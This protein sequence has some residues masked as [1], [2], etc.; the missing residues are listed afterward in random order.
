VD[1]GADQDVN[2]S[3]GATID[4]TVTDDGE[5]DPPGT[6]TVTWTKQSGPGTVTFGDDD[7]VDTT[8]AFSAGGVYVLRLTAD[9]SALTDYDEVEITVNTA[10]TVDAGVDQDVNLSAGATLDATVSDDGYP[11]PPGTYTVL[12]TKQSGPGT[13]TFGDDD[14]VDTTA[15]FSA[16][17]V[18]VLRLT[19]DDSAL[20]DYDEVEITVNT[21]PTVDA[22]SDQSVEISAGATLDATVSDDG[23]PD[24]PGTYTVT[25]TKQSGPGTVTFGNSAAVDTTAAFSATGVY[26]LRLT[27]DD[28]TL[29]DYDEVQITVT[30]DNTAPTVNAGL[31]DDITLPA[32]ITLDAT[33]SDDGLPDP[34]ATVTTTWTKQ[35]GPGT[36]TFGNSAAVD[37]T[38]EFS[39]AGTYVLRLTADDDDETAYDDVEITVDPMPTIAYTVASQ[40]RA[41]DY[42]QTTVVAELSAPGDVTIT[43]PYTVGGTATNPDDYTTNRSSPISFPPGTMTGTVTVTIVNDD[44]PESDETIIFTLGTPTNATLGAITQHTLT[45]TDNDTSNAAPT[46]DAGPD[47]A[48]NL[49]DSAT[50]DATVTDDGLPDP[51]ASVTT[52]WTKQSGPGTV[53]F[54]N[55]SAVDT[56]AAFS[57]TGTY[58]LRLTADD[59][60]LSEYDELTVVVVADT[61]FILPAKIEVEDYR[62]GGSGVGYY[63][64]TSGNAGGQYRSD[65]VDIWT[66]NDT[67]GGY[68]VGLVS[69]NEW[70]AYDIYVPET[71]LFTFT[72]RF[73]FIANH[74]LDLVVDDETV[75]TI[76][77]Y[78]TDDDWGQVMVRDVSITAGTHVLKLSF[79][80]GWNVDYINYLDVGGTTPPEVDAGPDQ[81]ITLPA[82][83]TLDGTVTDEGLPDPPGACT[84]RWTLISGPTY[85]YPYF[86][87]RLSV[88]TTVAF[89]TA[90]TYVLRLTADDG[91]ASVYDEMQVT[92]NQPSSRVSLPGRLQAEDYADQGEGVSYHDT[93][94]GNAGSVYRSDD[95]D[96]ESCGDTGGGY[97]V[98]WIVADEWLAFD[99]NVSA[100]TPCYDI[101]A[102]VSSTT[103][104]REMHV[105]VDDVDVTGPITFDSTGGWTDVTTEGVHLTAGRHT[106]KVV[107]DTEDFKLNYVDFLSE[108]YE[109]YIVENG[110]ANADIVISTSPSGPTTFAADELRDIILEMTGATLPIVTTPTGADVHIYVGQSSH[111]D[112]LGVTTSG[113]KYDSFKMVSGSDWL[114]LLGRDIDYELPAIWS[115]SNSSHVEA[116]DDYTGSTYL[117]PAVGDSYVA[118]NAATDLWYCDVCGSLQAVYEFCRDLGC[119]WYYPKTVGEVIPDLDDVGLPTVNRTVVADYPLHYFG[120]YRNAFLHVDEDEVKW[121]LR[122]GVKSGDDVQGWT[123]V[124]GTSLVHGRDEMKTEHPEY[125]QL[126][127]GERVLDGYAGYGNPCLSSSGL[128]AEN[129]NFAKKIFDYYGD[130]MISITPPDGYG[131]PHCE[132]EGCQ[133]LDT[134]ERG[135]FGEASDY[136]H[137]YSNEVAEEV[138]L[139]HPS[140]KIN[141]AAYGYYYLPPADIEEFS[142]NVVVK[143]CTLETDFGDEGVYE[144]YLELADDWLALLPSDQLVIRGYYLR[145]LQDPGNP[146]YYMP[147]VKSRLQL[148]KDGTA[149]GAFIE[150]GRTH[151]TN[152]E[153]DTPW[154]AIAA[155]HLN[156]YTTARLLWDADL[157]LAAMLDDYYEKFYGPAA[158]EMKD[159]VE[160]C[161]A[162]FQDFHDDSNILETERSLLDDAIDAAEGSGV[163]ADRV[164]LMDKYLQAAENEAP[165][166]SAGD[167]DEITLPNDATL[168]GTVT[169]DGLPTSPGTYTVLWT[170]VSGPGMVTFDDEDAVDTTAEFDTVGTYVLR[171]TAD[172]TYEDT[173]DD[174][175][176][177][178]N[179]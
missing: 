59:N 146:R 151:V 67:G 47:D 118:Y 33:V 159:F 15:A 112:S 125:Y 43:M 178:V 66:C 45:I 79:P 148:Y 100:D 21:A 160:Y 26:V 64:T 71:S 111:T 85:G 63:D 150:V 138:Y 176:I 73:K 93:T 168:D 31:D 152:G 102:R 136:V 55:A 57:T 49:S 39:T 131:N 103:S 108:S 86:T 130:P 61:T 48:I 116:W 16:G 69:A 41:E 7:A 165:E 56:T 10:P 133:G 177:T 90:G 127:D 139:T 42:G 162:N 143:I 68:M 62:P 142:P 99:V 120:F 163:Y 109:E 110:A 145:C 36:V 170:K 119:R 94:S 175:T 134:P 144:E 32:A 83:A 126:I 44:D 167:D 97:N 115:N 40:S 104:S 105:E 179:E 14:A 2:L 129:V 113:L 34:P 137:G 5:P 74:S 88:D 122:L 76:T 173:H 17:G 140:K 78:D 70:L 158:E 18:Y 84:T 141:I 13:V 65:D 89:N 1:V 37:T 174:V 52:T 54:G 166:V 22:G 95:V 169:D 6:Y 155:N 101:V 114:V 53:T 29:T 164:G 58:V 81:E 98:S 149:V 20:T 117:I 161:Q 28:S 135:Y 46:V 106:V 80:L 35:S 154:D 77:G 72:L 92:V 12:W 172:D 147:W 23:E 156:A 96:I 157:D 60:D 25:W 8:A 124:H 24:P 171:L 19:A 91:Q 153:P 87:D 128:L 75:A 50:L 11:N 132:C 107:M 9:D 38:A 4:A 123:H 51:P 27:A 30:A 3:A 82:T 121:Q